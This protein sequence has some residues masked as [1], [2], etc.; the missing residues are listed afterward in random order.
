MTHRGRGHAH[1]LR[2]SR[3]AS[4]A[5]KP[6]EREEKVQVEV[7]KV[8]PP[9]RR[10]SSHGRAV[11]WPAEHGSRPGL[12]SLRHFFHH[13]EEMQ[14][15]GLE[16]WVLLAIVTLSGEAYGV[17][18]HDRLSAAGLGASLGAI[19]TSLDRLERKALVTSHLGD[20]SASRGGRRKRLFTATPKGRKALVAN[21]AVRGRLLLVRTA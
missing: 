15:A 8:D 1:T 20:A 19:Y 17:S 3:H 10:E 4:L 5:E 14:L 6:V 18:I 2:G 11:A 21:D 7:R 12:A 13:A 9:H 16:E